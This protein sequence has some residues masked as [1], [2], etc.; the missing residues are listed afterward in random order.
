MSAA[1]HVLIFVQSTMANRVVRVVEDLHDT[2]LELLY[3]V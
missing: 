3:K 2:L 1:T